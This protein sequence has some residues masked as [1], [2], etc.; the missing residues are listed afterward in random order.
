MSWFEVAAGAPFG[1]EEL[2]YGIFSTAESTPRVGVAIGDRVL[3][4]AAV[5][6]AAGL[7]GEV[8][9]QPSLN[10]LLSLGPD[11]WAE[12][13]ELLQSLLE[14]DGRVATWSSR[15]CIRSTR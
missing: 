8:F 14:D 1:T 15:I 4:L 10:A 13:R 11:A 5:A 6:E 9:E 3:D 12:G 7:D 2:P